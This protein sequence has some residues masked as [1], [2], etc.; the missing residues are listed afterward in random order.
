M[1]HLASFDHAW[2]LASRLA[3]RLETD[4]V[5]LFTGDPGQPYAAE[6]D[7]GQPNAIAIITADPDI[8]FRFGSR[9]RRVPI[10]NIRASA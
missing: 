6:P 4:Y 7:E 9:S 10:Y 2:Q 1:A 8:A 5:V 3:E